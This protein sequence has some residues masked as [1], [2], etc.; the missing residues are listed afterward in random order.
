MSGSFRMKPFVAV[1]AMSSLLWGACA[2]AEEPAAILPSDIPA[3]FKPKTDGFDYVKREEMIPMRD[4]VKLKTFILVPKGATQAR[5]LLTRTPYNAS[6]RVLRFNSPRL[7]AVVPQMHDTSI[8]ADTSLL[9][10]PPDARLR[11]R[12]MSWHLFSILP[13]VEAEKERTGGKPR[14]DEAVARR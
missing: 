8:A 13:D 4:G 1:A 3:T 14:R 10:E 12:L 9:C 5:V 6:K 11:G 7:A 2:L